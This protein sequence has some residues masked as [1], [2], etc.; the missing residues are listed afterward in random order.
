MPLSSRI[1]KHIVDKQPES[2]YFAVPLLM[3]NAL[4]RP[5]LHPVRLSLPVDEAAVFQSLG[6]PSDCSISKDLR[7]PHREASRGSASLY[8]RTGQ[9]DPPWQHVQSR[10]PLTKR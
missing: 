6:A 9:K 5:S 8:N 4:W 3:G 7:R 2:K 1:D 10:C